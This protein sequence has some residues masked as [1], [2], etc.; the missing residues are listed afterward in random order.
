MFRFVM[1]NDLSKVLGIGYDHAV[2]R[3]KISIAKE[4]GDK[5]FSQGLTIEPR[6]NRVLIWTPKGNVY[7]VI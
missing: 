2:L 1:I 4:T 7:S 5:Q 6:N 3:S